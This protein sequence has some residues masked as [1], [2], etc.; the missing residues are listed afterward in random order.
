M[1]WLRMFYIIAS[2]WLCDAWR[3]PQGRYLLKCN[4]ALKLTLFA[5]EPS[6]VEMAYMHPQMDIHSFALN[7][8]SARCGQMHDPGS[9]LINNSGRRHQMYG[10]ET[11]HWVLL[12]RSMAD[13][14][15]LSSRSEPKPYLPLSDFLWASL[16][17]LHSED[18]TSGFSACS[19]YVPNT[20]AL[21]FISLL[22]LFLY[23][24]IW[25][26]E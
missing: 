14:V 21:E 18:F 7:G 2:K 5:C 15:K 17:D 11:N 26:P 12:N 22:S 13:T 10:A 20:V 8:L 16:R 3:C 9:V 4:Q 1:N 19:L 6:S 24:R 23:R 25:R